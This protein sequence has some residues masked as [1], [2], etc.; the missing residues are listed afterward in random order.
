MR[1]AK[2]SRLDGLTD[3]VFFGARR[4]VDVRYRNIR[5][6]AR[7]GLDFWLF[8]HPLS[9]RYGCDARISSLASVSRPR[10]RGSAISSIPPRKVISN[11]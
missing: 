1:V 6:M 7:P 5:R 11:S 9:L 3:G 8:T 10:T 4:L 2:S